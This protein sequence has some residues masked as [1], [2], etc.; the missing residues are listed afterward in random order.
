MSQYCVGNSFT[1]STAAD[2]YF[3]TSPELL[4]FGA[5]RAET[6]KYNLQMVVVTKCTHST[7]TEDLE[8]FII[9]KRD[10]LTLDPKKSQVIALKVPLP[11]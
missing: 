8:Y 7:L 4:S 5:A 11:K 6:E 3:V 1:S 9:L 2:Y 10:M